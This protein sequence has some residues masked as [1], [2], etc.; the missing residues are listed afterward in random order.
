MSYV[1]GDIVLIV[2]PF[3]DLTGRKIR[4]AIVLSDLNDGDLLVAR[5][6]SK[7]Q[8]SKFDYYLSSWKKLNLLKPSWIRMHKLSTLD[9]KLAKK[10]IG[11]LDSKQMK[12]ISLIFKTVF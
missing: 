3:T 12:S 5:I 7:M 4:P 11:Q 10:K 6:T 9:A 1:K 8:A 2:F